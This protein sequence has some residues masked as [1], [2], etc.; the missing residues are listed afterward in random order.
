MAKNYSIESADRITIVRFIR[1][2]ELED[3]CKAIDDVAEN[4]LSEFRL[5]DFSCGSNLSYTEIEQVAEYGKSKFLI[6]SKVAIIAQDD[7]TFGSARVHDVYREN[8]KIEERV[9]R[10]EKEAISWLKSH[11]T[12]E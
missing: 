1:K 9:F 2:L 11:N 4:Y 10:T 8:G 6:P 5:W 3:I 12:P 7:L